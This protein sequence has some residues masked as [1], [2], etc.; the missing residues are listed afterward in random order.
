LT[1]TASWPLPENNPDPVLAARQ[2]PQQHV[3]RLRG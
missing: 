3:T 1:T 2:G